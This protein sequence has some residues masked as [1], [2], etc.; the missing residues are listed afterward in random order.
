MK[1][2]LDNCS[3]QRPLD[4]KAQV[5]IALEAEA[6]LSILTLCESGDIDLLSSDALLFEVRRT[7]HPTRRDHALAI[8]EQATDHVELT[9]GVEARVKALIALGIKPLDGLHLACAEAASADYFCTCD[10]RLLRQAQRIP[11]FGIALVSP[12]ELIAELTTDDS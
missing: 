2:Y 3:L 12:L 11:D 4:D 6:I 7:P 5:R 8:L 9:E 1:V 10:D